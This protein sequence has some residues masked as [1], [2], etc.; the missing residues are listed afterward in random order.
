MKSCGTPSV[1]GAPPLSKSN[2]IKIQVRI[3]RKAWETIGNR[4]NP[5]KS[6]GDPMGVLGLPPSSGH[7]APRTSERCALEHGAAQGDRLGA[8]G[9]RGGAL[10]S[11]LR[12]DTAARKY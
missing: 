11:A 5:L 3:K 6:C 8:P 1:L 2:Q 7:G 10:R 9:P 4:R 12:R